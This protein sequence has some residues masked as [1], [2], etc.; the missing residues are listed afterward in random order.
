MTHSATTGEKSKQD[1]IVK[2]HRLSHGT[3]IC[4]DM[5]RTRRFYEEFL[6]LEVV[7]HAP[8]AMMFRLSTG[9]HVVCV[10]CGPSKLWGMHVLH[11]WGI[12]VGTEKEVDDAYQSALEHKDEYGIRAIMKPVTQHGAYSFYLQDLDQNWW[13][14]QCSPLDHEAYFARGDVVSS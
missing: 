1:S 8:S 5:Q 3:L 13:E 4:A 14:I 7:R 12:D 10:E 11:H 6:G 9:I 2:P